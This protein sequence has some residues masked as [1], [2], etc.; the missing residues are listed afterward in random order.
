MKRKK[1]YIAG[2]YRG[3]HALVIEENIRQAESSILPIA[4]AGGNPFCPHSMF[5]FFQGTL[6][7]EFW[8]DS[9]LEWLETCDALFLGK[10]WHRSKGS[11]M[12]CV[13]AV[14]IGI[15][16]FKKM[17]DL[18]AWLTYGEDDGDC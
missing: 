4:E 9:T 10:G 1:V 8:L 13:R 6:P 14:E 3:P 12:E 2:P 17:E 18:T 11:I 7:D 16:V 5:R 15:P